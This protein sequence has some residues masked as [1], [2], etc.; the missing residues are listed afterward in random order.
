MAPWKRLL[1]S[2]YYPATYPYRHWWNRQLALSGR[3]PIMVVL[4]HRVAD[5]TANGWTTRTETFIRDIHWLKAHFELVSLEEA[6]NRIR[7][8]TN[9]R[10]CVAVT[11]DDGYASN[12]DVAL[13]LLID[14]GIP[15]TYFVTTENVLTGKPFEHDLA[16]GNRFE[17]N[18]AS[19]LRE[20][21]EAGI[22]IGAHTRTHPHLGLIKDPA[23]RYD[24]IVAARNDLQD[25][26]GCL[27]RRFAVPFGQHEHLSDAVFNLCYEAGFECVVSAYGGYNWPC[28][29]AFHL[30]RM[31]V[32]GPFL[33][34]KNW[35]TLDPLKLLRIKR[36]QYCLDMDSADSPAAGRDAPGSSPSHSH[37][38]SR[39]GAAAQSVSGVAA[40]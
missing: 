8:A 36:F 10:P 29:D 38:P 33:R 35:T 1:L 18:N 7:T 9:H 2:L 14:E 25:A 21:A 30:Q 23:E 11:F 37:E 39:D 6:Q 27:V 31:G 24:E 28:G 32:D 3:A 26:L 19:Q 16:M 15:C 4:F 12:C 13:P 17:P 20:A 40:P 34:M 22:E 5:D